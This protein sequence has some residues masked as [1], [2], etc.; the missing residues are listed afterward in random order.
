MRITYQKKN[1][2]VITENGL[3]VISNLNPFYPINVEPNQAAEEHLSLQNEILLKPIADSDL[4]DMSWFLYSSLTIWTRRLLRPQWIGLRR[5]IL[6][7][8]QLKRSSSDTR[9]KLQENW[10]ILIS[11][12][13]LRIFD[14]HLKSKSFIQPLSVTTVQDS[15]MQK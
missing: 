6:L 1:L 9:S 12:N 14:V 11:Q 13:Y 15:P 8:N 7:I 3:K 2:A 5:D 10:L 4:I